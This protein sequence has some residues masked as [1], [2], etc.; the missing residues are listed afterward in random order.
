MTM[1]DAAPKK[2]DSTYEKD[3]VVQIINSVISKVGG[4]GDLSRDA[5]FKELG[6]LKKIIEDARAEMRQAGASDIKGKHIPTATDE[7][8]EVVKATAEATGTIMDACDVIQEKAGAAGGEN[9]DAIGAEVMKIYEAC[10][11]QDI[12]GQRITK[13]VTSLKAIEE[14]VDNLMAVLG[15]A[16]SGA[17]AS[18]VS[19]DART[20]DEALLNG[21]QMP[22]QAM[23]QEDID[24]LLSELFD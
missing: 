3:Q 14:K 23:G 10:S 17:A 6:D 2:T 12:T 13:V 16:S 15:G 7:L 4:T 20:G 5:I 24:D 18:A 19:E 21:P 11:F 22:D 9:G 1:S 8:D